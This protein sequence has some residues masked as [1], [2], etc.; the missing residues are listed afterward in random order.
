MTTGSAVNET[1]PA[2]K[3]P[4]LDGTTIDL[5]SYRGKKIIIFMWASW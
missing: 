3:L 2:A 1:L 4:S 5:A